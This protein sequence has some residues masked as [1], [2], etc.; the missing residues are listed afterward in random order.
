MANFINKTLNFQ[1]EIH[2]DEQS[3]SFHI[4]EKGTKIYRGDSYYANKKDDIEKMNIDMLQGQK[5]V[6]FGFSQ[7]DI[8]NYNYGKPFEFEVLSVNE[9]SMDVW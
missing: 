9:L 8:E 5:K 6:F 4:I 1:E 7:Y 3:L 2:T